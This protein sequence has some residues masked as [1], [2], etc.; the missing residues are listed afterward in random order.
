M[1]VNP[2][3]CNSMRKNNSSISNSKISMIKNNNMTFGAYFSHGT[4]VW[5]KADWEA[6]ERMGKFFD[7]LASGVL[8]PKRKVPKD[9][10][11]AIGELN[12]MIDPDRLVDYKKRHVHIKETVQDGD[13]SKVITHNVMR[14]TFYDRLKQIY[15]KQDL[16][17]DG[18]LETEIKRWGPRGKIL[19]LQ[20]WTEEINLNL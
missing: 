2:I 1:R 13:I 10:V 8:D 16:Y 11:W 14:T 15:Y 9:G 12:E 4:Q 7:K 17:P 5:E 18:K 3:M 6:L 20:T 19:D